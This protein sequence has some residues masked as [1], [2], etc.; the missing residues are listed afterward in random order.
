MVENWWLESGV[1]RYVTLA[2]VVAPDVEA[3]V[4]SA[5]KQN[6]SSV[7]RSDNATHGAVGR[8]LMELLHDLLLCTGG[9]RVR[10]KLS[11]GEASDVT[12]DTMQAV[13]A[14]VV[15]MM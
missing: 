4:S 2:E 14:C 6:K 1:F 10:D 9:P 13:M 3:G 11:H 5:S 8:G 7:D 15:A 12:T